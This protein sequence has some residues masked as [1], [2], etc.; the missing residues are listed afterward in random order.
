MLLLSVTQVTCRHG[1]MALP[2]Y[3]YNAVTDRV[4]LDVYATTRRE[5]LG[6]TYDECNEQGAPRLHPEITML[7][8]DDIPMK[9]ICDA[10][11]G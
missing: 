9:R 8:L 4:S 2:G 3:H 11:E 6:Y 5:E 1:S 7:F 10:R